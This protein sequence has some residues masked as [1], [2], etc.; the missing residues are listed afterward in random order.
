[1]SEVMVNIESDEYYEDVIIEG[2]N[3][4]K[5][6]VLLKV[7]YGTLISRFLFWK[8]LTEKISECGFETNPYEACV[9][10][11]EADGKQY[12]VIC[13]VDYIKISH[14]D[15]KVV[16]SILRLL[17]GSYGRTAPLT[18]PRGKIHNCL[19]TTL[20]LYKSGRVNVKIL[21]Y[22]NRTLSDAPSDLVGEAST[23]VANQPFKV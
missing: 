9:V 21:K 16:E 11:K 17:E 20:E 7:F 1:M 2:G 15:I 8:D 10:N 19:G 13:H 5:Y 22:I 3:K 12:T 18:V 6:A 23:L 14:I 4:V